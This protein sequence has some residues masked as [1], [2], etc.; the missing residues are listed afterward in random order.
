MKVL[1]LKLFRS[2]Q[3][4]YLPLKGAITEDRLIDPAIVLIQ[5]VEQRTLRMNFCHSV[6]KSNNLLR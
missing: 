2:Y 5:L 4:P 3:T 1:L 6:V